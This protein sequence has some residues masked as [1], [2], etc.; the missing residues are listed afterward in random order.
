[1]E[2]LKKGLTIQM[3]LVTANI[4]VVTWETH[5]HVQIRKNPARMVTLAGSVTGML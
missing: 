4:A 3:S 2:T 1:M 5:P